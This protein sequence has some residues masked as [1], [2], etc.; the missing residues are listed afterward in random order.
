MLGG[1]RAPDRVEHVTG[2]LYVISGLRYVDSVAI[3]ATAD[4]VSE[5]RPGSTSSFRKHYNILFQ[6]AFLSPPFYLSLGG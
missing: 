5:S 6:D 4:G 1:G 2:P 3:F